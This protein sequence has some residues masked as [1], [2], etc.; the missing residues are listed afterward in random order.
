MFLLE[1]QRQMKNWIYHHSTGF[2]NCTRVLSN[3]LYCWICQ[4]I[5]ETSFQLLTCILSTVKTGIQSYCNI[6][7]SRGG[8]NQMWFLKNSKDLLEDIQSR[9]HFFCN[10][11]KTFDFS[12][13]YTTIPHS[14]LKDKLREL[15]QLCFIKMNGQRR[16]KSLVLGRDRSY[17]VKHHSDYTNKFSETDIFNMLEF[18]I[19]NIFVIF[20]GRV[21]Q[22]T[23]GIHMG[24]NCA[25]PLSPCSFIRMRQISYRGFSRKTKIR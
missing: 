23:I 6:S 18:L 16:Y 14:K 21:F 19:D 15:V 9:S 4:M 11:I 7:Y 5:H 3:R 24:T 8:V 25:P 12:A 2:L 10:S 17:F 22:Q 1:F 20:G 13:L